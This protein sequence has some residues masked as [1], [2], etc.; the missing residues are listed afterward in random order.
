MPYESTLYNSDKE[1]GIDLHGRPFGNWFLYQ[2]GILNGGNERAEF[3][4]F[5]GLVCHDPVRLCPV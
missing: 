1:L 5:K 3:E 4:S 2:V